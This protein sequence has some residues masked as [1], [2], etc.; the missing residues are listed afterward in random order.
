M[1]INRNNYEEYF[2]LYADKELPAHEKN[3]VEMFVQQNPDLE[4]EFIM[5]QQSVVKPDNTITLEDKNSLFRKEEFINQDNYEEKFLLYADNELSLSEIEETE[6]FAL[7][8]PS[9][10]A[11]FALL[12]QVTFK[13]DTS[14]VFPR[15]QLLYKKE[16]DAKVIPFRWKALA[17][18]VLLGLGLWTGIS[19]LQKEKTEPVIVNNP[20]TKSK[21]NVVVK[22]VEEPT[23]KDPV[24]TNDIDQPRDSREQKDQDVNVPKQENV[25]VKD[26]RVIK[27]PEENKLPEPKQKEIVIQD[28]VVTTDLV[29][30]SNELPQPQTNR[31]EPNDKNVTRPSVP[32]TNNYAMPASYINDEEVKSD[33]YVFFHITAEEFK[34]SKVG[35][36]LK[37]VKRSV[38]RRIPFKGNGLKIG[39]VEISKDIQ[40]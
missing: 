13:P 22:P 15:K 20:N 3:M 26:N 17:A 23:Q 34:K 29:K 14:I 11:E 36:F 27:Q 2:L 16:E 9:L 35:N 25:A 38:E 7:A 6:K 21:N 33:N 10:Q 40:N 5:L 19:Y 24:K 28:A 1:N 30:P 4:E 37:K 18:A 8:N 12:Q 39:S 32:E 31:T